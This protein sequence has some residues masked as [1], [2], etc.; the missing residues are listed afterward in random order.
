MPLA[1]AGNLISDNMQNWPTANIPTAQRVCTLCQTGN[2]GDEQ[3]VVFECLLV[4]LQG[5]PAR[6]YEI[7]TTTLLGFMPLQ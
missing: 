6:E 4:A 2:L 1:P 3:H 5:F 7:D